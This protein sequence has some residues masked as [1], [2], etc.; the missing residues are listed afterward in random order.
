MDSREALI[1]RTQAMIDEAAAYD[2]A[3]QADALW[4]ELDCRVELMIIQEMQAA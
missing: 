3:D 1:A 4:G 2:G